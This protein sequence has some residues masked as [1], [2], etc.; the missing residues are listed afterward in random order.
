MAISASKGTEAT[1]KATI[2]LLNC[3]AM[4]PDTEAMHQASDM[5]LRVDSDAACLVAPEAK[6]RAGGC[7]HLTTKDGQLFNGPALILAKAIKNV[8]A[9]E[10]EA[11]IGALFM[12][13]Q[14]AVALRNCLEAMGHPQPPTSIKTDNNTAQGIINNTMKQKRSKA[15]YM[16]FHWL[17]DRVNQNQF[18]VYWESGEDQLH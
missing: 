11:K 4:H 3:A 12:N 15:I 18:H 8:M 2:H 10:A 1:L 13:A 17:R 5:T 16:R 9:S 6:S 7:H 14:E